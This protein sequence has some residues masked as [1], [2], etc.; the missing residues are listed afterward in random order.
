MIKSGH[1]ND[2]WSSYR[3]G[4]RI[5]IIYHKRGRLSQNAFKKSKRLKYLEQLEDERVKY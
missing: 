2:C 1:I 4:S 5:K 3:Y